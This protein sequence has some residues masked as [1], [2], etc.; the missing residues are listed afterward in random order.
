MNYNVHDMLCDLFT[1][2][3][4]ENMITVA[5]AKANELTSHVNEK[6][7]KE[8]LAGVPAKEKRML[9][10]G[11]ANP[12]TDPEARHPGKPSAPHLTLVS[13]AKKAAELKKEMAEKT[14][15]KIQN[16]G[17]IK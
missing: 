13:D 12:M 1:E 16:P 7:A 3:K 11:N 15:Q 8:A 2:C 9:L 4:D 14:A 6:A 5:E 17:T 10:G